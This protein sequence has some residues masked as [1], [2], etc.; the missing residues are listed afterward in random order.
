M[1]VEIQSFYP[2]KETKSESSPKVN[3]SKKPLPKRLS[4]SEADRQERLKTLESYSETHLGFFH[5]MKLDS[6]SLRGN[7]ES[8]IGAVEIPVGVAGPLLIEGQKVCDE[9]FAPLA[10]SEGALVSSVNRGALAL[11]M[12]GGVTARVLKQRMV[13]APLFDCESISQ[14]QQL[15]AWIE[16]HLGEIKAKV[17]KHSNH[18]QL[19][20]LDFRMIAPCL[21]VQFIYETGDASGQ[22]MVTLCTWN[23][24]Q[25]ILQEFEKQAT[26]TIRQFIIDGNLST[27]KKASNISAIQ[28]RGREV[29][30]EAVI[31]EPIVRRILRSNAKD[32]VAYFKKAMATSVLTGTQGVNV[33][34]A[35][36]VAAMFASTGQDI[37]CVHESA[38]GQVYFEE[39]DKDL[40][41]S[42]LMPNLVI[43][44]VGGGVSMSGQK[45]LL[46]SMGVYGPGGADRLAE[47]IASFALALELSTGAALTSGHFV[48]AHERL[49]RNKKSY[50]KNHD[51]FDT[52]LFN[53][54]LTDSSD[55]VIQVKS[56]PFAEASESFVVGLAQQV[57][58][59]PCGL[60]L[61]E[62]SKKSGKK[63]K[64]L[65]KVKAPD[66]EL[67]LSL[68]IL[69]SLKSPGLGELLRE[70]RLD[71]PFCH[72]P[73]R[74]LK[75]V[76]LRDSPIQ[77]VAPKTLGTYFDEN[78]GLYVLAQ[79]FLQ[80]T[81]LMNSIEKNEKWKAGDI[82][83]AL[84]GIA[85]VHGHF[86]NQ[87]DQ[88]KNETWIRSVTPEQIQRTLDP[89]FELALQMHYENMHWLSEKDV[90]FHEKEL[91]HLVPKWN[92]LM[93]L[94]QTLVHNDFNPRNLTFRKQTDALVA[95]DWE[96]STVFVP[97][98]DLAELLSFTLNC[99]STRQDL[100]R[101]SEFHRMAVE[102]E[103]GVKLTEEEWIFGL[104]VSL[105][106]FILHRLPI[107]VIP[108]I[109]R[110]VPFLQSTYQ[111]A[112]H[113]LN[114]V[115]S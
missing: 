35:N 63:Q 86:L 38:T 22:N 15:Q 4:F 6:K 103:S 111:T 104:E 42:L 23:I 54:I 102:K 93:Q 12:A 69:A 27:D 18:A 24:C 98:R 47:I 49:G 31:P 61:Y 108:Q 36:I 50:W 66:K 29:V 87:T 19:L 91:S 90:Q 101:F 106:D 110:Q 96:L 17:R 83:S 52:S 40:Y 64:S 30:V 89:H 76:S 21:H 75:V 62:L 112:R 55:E 80:E 99:E 59:R 10:T 37:A 48:D 81:R 74:E 56:L 88:F 28:G 1:D 67:L 71:S 82:E 33:N 92:Q 51:D 53:Q 115:R 72:S 114:L 65:L 109:V 94:P 8:L 20:E 113:L 25:W 41:I 107:Y 7:I 73:L 5:S 79:E 32:M 44:S 57:S 13:R 46:Q 26:F 14:C 100:I 43:G 70:N 85:K 58:Q 97:Q 105:L 78:S 9:V 95:Y 39:R 68:E 77:E 16:S 2:T 34:V 84:N 3:K 11:N 45:Q 60:W